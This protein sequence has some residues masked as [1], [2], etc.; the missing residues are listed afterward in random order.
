MSAL[1][2]LSQD[3]SNAPHCWHSLE[4][5]V[6]TK[7][8]MCMCVCNCLN[9]LQ[10][11]THP[12]THI[13]LRHCYGQHWRLHCLLSAKLLYFYVPLHR[14]AR[15]LDKLHMEVFPKF[16]N[17][18]WEANCIPSCK[19]KCVCLVGWVIW[20]PNHLK[21]LRAYTCTYIY[22]LQPPLLTNT[23]SLTYTHT[24]TSPVCDVGLEEVP[25]V[26]GHQETLRYLLVH[27]MGSWE[28][29]TWPL[30]AVLHKLTAP[31]TSI[32]WSRCIFF[33]S[34]WYFETQ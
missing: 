2:E 4:N 25:A 14:V 18:I 33:D 29:T 31:Q 7:Y 8:T 16:I 3:H 17:T 11:S 24:H 10:A 21:L 13:T 19:I 23:Q 1:N 32:K 34:R 30:L 9:L 15:L 5:S 20:Q 12:P 28:R 22:T 6:Q 26:N 27:T